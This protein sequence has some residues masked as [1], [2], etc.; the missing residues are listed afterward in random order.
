MDRQ[1]A[2]TEVKTD[3]VKEYVGEHGT[4]GFGTDMEASITPTTR[5]APC[6]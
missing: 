5:R 3:A 2:I 4:V 1:A 6:C